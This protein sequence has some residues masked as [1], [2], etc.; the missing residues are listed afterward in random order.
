MQAVK[1]SLIPTFNS[2]SR[3]KT[4]DGWIFYWC[5]Y[6]FSSCCKK[7]PIKPYFQFVPWSSVVLYITDWSACNTWLMKQSVPIFSHSI[8][9]TP[10]L[11]WSTLPIGFI[12]MQVSFTQVCLLFLALCMFSL[13]PNRTVNFL[14][15]FFFLNRHSGFLI[16]MHLLQLQV[17]VKHLILGDKISQ[18]Q[19][20]SHAHLL[21]GSYS[22]LAVVFSA[23]A[24][25]SMSGLSLQVAKQRQLF[26]FPTSQVKSWRVRNLL[27][28]PGVVR[29]PVR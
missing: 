13:L 6:F 21:Y 3:Y 29:S 2:H 9:P 25:V 14:S 27:R 20:F 5:L 10:R 28:G 12:L 15:H 17:L 23:H 26:T 24:S 16:F 22:T 1:P 4:R 19:S 11:L 7:Q 18:L 8:D